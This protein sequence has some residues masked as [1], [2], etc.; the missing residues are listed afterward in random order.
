MYRFQSTTHE[1][2]KRRL[3]I[4]RQTAGNQGNTARGA[5]IPAKPVRNV[6]LPLSKMYRPGRRIDLRSRVYPIMQKN[7]KNLPIATLDDA[8]HV[9]IVEPNIARPPSPPP[10]RCTNGHNNLVQELDDTQNCN[11][12]DSTVLCTTQPGH[13]S[14][15]TTGAS[16][17]TE[18]LYL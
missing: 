15:Q 4:S 13:L 11:C 1:Q 5:S 8:S 3:C 12:G 17:T 6:P 7:T 2:P 10:S 16:T 9:S 18:E 14:L